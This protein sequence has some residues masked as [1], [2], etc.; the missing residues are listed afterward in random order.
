MQYTDIA[1]DSKNIIWPSSLLLFTI[2][3][4]GLTSFGQRTMSSDNNNKIY[5]YV[6]FYNNSYWRNMTKWRIYTNLKAFKAS[7]HKHYI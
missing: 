1:L 3:V 6:A 5:C 7:K 4:I 2:I